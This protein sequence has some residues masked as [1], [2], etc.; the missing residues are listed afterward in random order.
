MVLI[1]LVTDTRRLIR[2]RVSGMEGSVS[3]KVEKKVEKYNSPV[4]S[5]NI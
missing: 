5:F 1:E 3:V 4:T 2:L